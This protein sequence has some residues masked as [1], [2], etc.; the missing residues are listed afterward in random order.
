MLPE[1][2]LKPGPRAALGRCGF[3]L[4]LAA[5]LA[6][7]LTSG[8]TAADNY[9][10]VGGLAIYLGVLPAQM[11]QGH[12]PEHPEPKMHG[13]APAARDR[14]HIVVAVFDA[15]TGA[16]I[17]DAEVTAKVGEPGL[18]AV[19]RKLAPMPIAGAMSYGNY[20]A[21]PSK[22]PYRIDVRVVQLATGRSV[23]ATFSYTPAR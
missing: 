4:V 17:D 6:A 11:L 18:T 8:A 13:G 21:M 12:V 15:S 14:Q 1:T 7:G 23:V 19:E 3:R 2:K 10:S 20:F 16:R 5:S 9:R 22:G